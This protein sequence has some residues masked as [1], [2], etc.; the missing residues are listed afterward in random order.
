MNTNIKKLTIASMLG[1]SALG[2]MSASA[3]G[4]GGAMHNLTP[5]EIATRQTTMFQ[6]QAAM[7]GTTVD[8]VKSA[9]ASGKDLLTLAKEKG[10]TQADLQ[11]KMKA[12]R[13]AQMKAELQTLVTK[14]VITQ[15][16]ADARY[17]YM[18]TKQTGKGGHGHH[19]GMGGM[20]GGL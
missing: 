12:A 6:T 2:I 20:M 19:G 18:T 8:E 9:W 14:G 13:D 7:L 3:M 4:M 16:Q 10:I 11:K 15:A 5:D 1:V 17:T